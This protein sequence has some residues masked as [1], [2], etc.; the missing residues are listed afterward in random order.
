MKGRESGMPVRDQWENFF[1]AEEIITCLQC[2][3]RSGDV[4]EFGCGYG[5]FSL[6]V[7]R[8]LHGLL[9]TFDI[10]PAMV[11]ETERRAHA[12]ELANLI[13]RRRDFVE[14]GT[15]L[16]DGAAVHA[17]LFNLLH[18]EAPVRLLREARRVLE[19]GGAASII[20]W[21]TDIETPRGPSPAIRPTPDQCRCWAREAGFRTVRPVELGNA[22]PWHFGMIVA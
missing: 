3:E 10:D 18:I 7:A 22:A 9:H 5:T 19:P 21:R 15:G 17:M 13:V 6:P 16:A 4:I 2:A 12:E 14:D 11:A 1:D 8:R 20:H